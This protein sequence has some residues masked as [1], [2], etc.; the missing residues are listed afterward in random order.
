MP[1]IERITVYPIKSLD[2]VD[3][4]QAKITEGGAL[5][6]DRAFALYNESGRT[7][8]AKKYPAILKVRA[9]FDLEHL[10]VHLSTAQ[11]QLTFQ[12]PDDQ[13][14]I[15]Q[16]FSEYFGEPI[17]MKQNLTSGFPDDDE[18]SGP[19]LVSTASFLEVQKWFPELSLESLRKRFRA[20]IELGGCDAA[21]WEDQ[22]FSAP[23]LERP[24]TNKTFQIGE[25][26]FLGKKPCARCTVPTRDPFSSQADKSFMQSFITMREQTL[27]SF[28]EVAQFK[29]YYHL[30]VNTVIP[31]SAFGKFI[32]P[33]D[34]VELE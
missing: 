11:D 3:V 33:G 13:D 10:T 29:H 22:L 34:L 16:F 6:W 30:C 5:Q 18:N 25:V 17:H 21:F 14:R 4:Q 7:V 8:N 28:T 26:A 2:G 27:P 1:Y 24:S 31:A 20:N 15:A 23:G 9:H 32:K 12:L 19:T